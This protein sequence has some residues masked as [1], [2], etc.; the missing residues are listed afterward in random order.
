MASVVNVEHPT[1]VYKQGSLGP[2]GSALSDHN[3]SI[4]DHGCDSVMSARV[5]NAT[6]IQ[7][8]AK[9]IYPLWFFTSAIILDF[10]HL[11]QYMLL[12]ITNTDD[13][14]QKRLLEQ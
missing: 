11:L 13:K 9:S 4:C 8:L 6:V 14:R 1:R 12:K 10:Y 2:F 7:L 5:P 3:D